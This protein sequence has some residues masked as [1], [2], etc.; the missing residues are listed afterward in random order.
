MPNA[1][2]RQ[3]WYHDLL[4]PPTPN[5]V[6]QGLNKPDDFERA[7][8]VA[9]RMLTVAHVSLVQLQNMAV[10]TGNPVLLAVVEQA[11]NELVRLPSSMVPMPAELE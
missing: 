9:A 10:K 3:P 2:A 6:A 7:L 1:L 8:V 11:I 5:Q 4:T